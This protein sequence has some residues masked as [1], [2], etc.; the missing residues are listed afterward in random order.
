MRKRG[1]RRRRNL[2]LRLSDR[3]AENQSSRLPVAR[4]R[5]RRSQGG[6]RG[7]DQALRHR[8][9][10]M[11]LNFHWFGLTPADRI[12]NGHSF[13]VE[14]KQDLRVCQTRK[15]PFGSE[16]AVAAVFHRRSLT[17]QHLST[18]VGTANYINNLAEIT[19]SNRITDRGSGQGNRKPTGAFGAIGRST[20]LLP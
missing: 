16:P 18:S 12:V 20:G 14:R 13:A 11:F 4:G 17:T 2:T 9:K 19:S 1:L 8:P 5:T 3:W 7:D 15:K 6:A 10:R